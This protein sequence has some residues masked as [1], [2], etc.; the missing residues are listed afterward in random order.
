MSSHL[1]Y[2]KKMF[3]FNCYNSRQKCHFVIIQMMEIKEYNLFLTN[4]EFI[5][6][7]T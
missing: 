7:S 6:T 3:L 4:Y 2:H 5:K 1:K